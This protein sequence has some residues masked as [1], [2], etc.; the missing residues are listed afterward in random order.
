MRPEELSNEDL[1]DILRILK[2]TGISPCRYEEECLEEAAR[3]LE[4]TNEHIDIRNKK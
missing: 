4:E 3:R 2:T 1:A